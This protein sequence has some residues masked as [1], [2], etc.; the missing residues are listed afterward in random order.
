MLFYLVKQVG[1]YSRQ[2]ISPD[3]DMLRDVVTMPGQMVSTTSQHFKNKRNVEKMYV[4]TKFK[5][6]Q[7]RLTKR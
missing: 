1:I 7:T 2:D 5:L 3:V 4:E 6:I